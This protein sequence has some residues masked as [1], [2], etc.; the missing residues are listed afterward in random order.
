MSKIKVKPGFLREFNN[1]KP[2][3]AF[4][5]LKKMVRDADL[6]PGGSLLVF[7]VVPKNAE[8]WLKRDAKKRGYH[9]AFAGGSY[10]LNISTKADRDRAA[11]QYTDLVQAR[12]DWYNS[13]G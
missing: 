12:E 13:P 9:L 7:D 10:R 3:E 2:E 6:G 1:P 4:E 8:T 11:K 5:R